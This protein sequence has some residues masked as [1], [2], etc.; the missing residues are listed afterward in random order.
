MAVSQRIITH[1]PRL[2]IIHGGRSSFAIPYFETK[3]LHKRWNIFLNQLI[4]QMLL[5][6]TT[7]NVNE[8]VINMIRKAFE[9]M[10]WLT[11]QLSHGTV[12]VYEIQYGFILRV[13]TIL[14][15][16]A[17]KHKNELIQLRLKLEE[18]LKLK[19]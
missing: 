19:I 15:Q 12:A 18:F 11:E 4:N 13:L 7:G 5:V 9:S 16:Y 14:D 2:R 1:G 17:P 3:D 6:Q 10:I 8:D